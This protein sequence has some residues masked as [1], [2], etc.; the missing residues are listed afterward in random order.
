M[1]NFYAE[2]RQAMSTQPEYAELERRLLEMT[3]PYCRAG[4]PIVRGIH[5]WPEQLGW[6]GSSW[7]KCQQ[8]PKIIAAS[9]PIFRLFVEAREAA[10]RMEEHYAI[11]C[12]KSLDSCKRAGYQRE[13][14]ATLEGAEGAAKVNHRYILSREWLGG[15][16]IAN[17]IML[18]PSTADDVFDEAITEIN[19]LRSTQ[20]VQS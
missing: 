18:N 13:K 12:D 9:L 16:G 14:A 11:C 6:E 2:L 17:F 8:D 19:R 4:K 15:Y 5:M 20:E 10:I 1:S 7:A 3:C